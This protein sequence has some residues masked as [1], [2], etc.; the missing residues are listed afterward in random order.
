MCFIDYVFTVIVILS[1]PPEKFATQQQRNE[2]YR[3]INKG[4]IPPNKGIRMQYNRECYTCGS[5]KTYHDLKTDKTHW[6]LNRDA[7]GNAM[8]VLCHKCGMKYIKNPK[9][10]KAIWLW[11]RGKQIPLKHNPRTGFCSECG[12]AGQTQLH[13]TSYE[14]DKPLDNTVELCISCHNKIPKRKILVP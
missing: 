5:T 14:S 6:I 7:N 1:V 10:K 11:F 3:Q 13:H 8:Q 9:R 4:Q 2:Y 12:K